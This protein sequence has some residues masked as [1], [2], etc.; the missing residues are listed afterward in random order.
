MNRIGV[1][2]D[3]DEKRYNWTLPLWAGKFV[4]HLMIQH[5]F[6]GKK[7]KWPIRFNDLFLKINREGKPMTL[8]QLDNALRCKN[9]NFKGKSELQLYKDIEKV[10]MDAFFP[11][12]V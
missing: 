4:I 12:A 11:R 3:P 10:F 6:T 9:N 8:E 1:K 2:Y 7:P 5:R